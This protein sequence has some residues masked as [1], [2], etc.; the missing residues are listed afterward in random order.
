MIVK[1]SKPITVGGELLTEITLRDPT[2]DDVA[3]IGYPFLLDISDG[4]TSIRLQPKV[5]LKYASALAGVPPSSLKAISLGD[6]SSLQEAVMNFF[7]D[8]AG[9]S[10]N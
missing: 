7:G 1:L 10:Q 5:I 6:L 2:V 4:G 3:N 9:T 8:A